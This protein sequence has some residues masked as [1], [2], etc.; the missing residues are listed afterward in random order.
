MATYKVTLR[1]PDGEKV[2]DVTDVEFI[3]EIAN[4]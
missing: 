4:E 3:L 1:T 2:I